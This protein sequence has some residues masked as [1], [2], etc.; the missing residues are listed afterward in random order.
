MGSNP[1]DLKFHKSQ[2]SRRVTIAVWLAV[3]LLVFLGFSRL[4]LSVW[5]SQEHRQALTYLLL[6]FA[7]ISP[8][9]FAGNLF[10]NLRHII[11]WAIALMLLAYGYTVWC[12][13]RV[14]IRDFGGALVPHHN[15]ASLT[16]KAQF[17]KSAGGDFIITG[18]VNDVEVVFLLDT[19]ATDVMLTQRDAERIGMVPDDM[20]FSRLYQTANGTVG[21]APVR[22]SALTIGGIRITNIRA[23]VTDGALHRSLLG[24]SYLSRLSE[25]SVKGPI[26][27]FYQ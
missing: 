16:G 26:L 21:G 9:F 7:V 5:A 11:C 24:M 12:A 25:F 17:F 27:S 20:I 22:L 15:S 1:P 3:V 13:D 14:G 19:G 18:L 4:N 8:L 10:K 23:S 6:L 2:N